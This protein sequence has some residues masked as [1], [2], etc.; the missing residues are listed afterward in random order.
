MIDAHVCFASESG[1]VHCNEGCLLWAKADIG[2]DVDQRGI[3]FRLR[4]FGEFWCA[5]YLRRCRIKLESGD[6]A[7]FI[8]PRSA[9]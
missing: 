6:A 2:T 9:A 4:F 3:R 5:V 7:D 1:H 8:C